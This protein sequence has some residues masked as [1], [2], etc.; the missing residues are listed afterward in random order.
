MLI[1]FCEDISYSAK[2][3]LIAKLYFSELYDS[4]NNTM[5]EWLTI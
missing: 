2:V 4:Y 3:T 1:E 5:I